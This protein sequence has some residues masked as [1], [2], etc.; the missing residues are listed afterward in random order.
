[1]T[2]GRVREPG[3]D[4]K[5]LTWTY[6][7]LLMAVV[8]F[9]GATAYG[10]FKLRHES[11]I[12]QVSSQATVWL[13]VSFEREY[14][15]LDNLL[16]RYLSGDPT[17]DGEAVL[18]QFDVLWSRIDLMQQG[19][20]A[21]P[22]HQLGAYHEV[23]PAS[24]A[25]LNRHEASLFEAVEAGR[26]LP[27]EFLDAFRALAEPIHRFMIDVHLNRSWTVDVREAQIKDT[28]LAIYLT[29]AGTVTS[30]LILFAIVILQL[31]SRQGY[32]MRTLE[33]LAQSKRDSNALREEVI[34]REQI[35]DER[36]GLL[37]DLEARNEE[38][39]RYAYTISHD[40]KSPLYTIQGFTGFL[41][42]DL[43]QGGTEKL[44]EDL[45]KIREAAQT[46]SKML[47]DI[48]NLSKLNLVQEGVQ[49]VNLA[50]AICRAMSSV[51]REISE[52]NVSIECASDLPVVSGEPQRVTEIFQNLISNAAKFMGEQENPLIEIGAS[53]TGDWVECYVR[54]N[55]IGIDEEYRERIFNLF[56]RLDTRTHGT[57]IGLAI[58]KRI[59][60]RHGGRIWIESDGPGK[61]CQ[62]NF[63]LPLAS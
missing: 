63:T 61:G 1:M 62:F 8:L 29:L 12:A 45:A 30:T 17:L 13:V 60:E 38:L 20:N 41:E 22:L 32:L 51:S 56:E 34:Y 25:M 36:A 9:A 10:I 24:L 5:P 3:H 54:D 46:M 15:V 19:V 48:L 26:P 42:R 50:D 40:L 53:V 4:Q 21:R 59:I 35:E 6:G 16:W 31:R 28:R 47:D 7:L 14:L 33:A 27:T 23:V 44:R 55:G 39:E 57:G 49:R 43:E 52:G 58:V 18:T 11:E 2:T 37:D